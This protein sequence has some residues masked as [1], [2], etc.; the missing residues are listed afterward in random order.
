MQLRS[1]SQSTLWRWFPSKHGIPPVKFVLKDKKQVA[2][3]Q[4]KHTSNPSFCD[5][6]HSKL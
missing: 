2:V 3:C 6:S 1:I 4:C 5:G